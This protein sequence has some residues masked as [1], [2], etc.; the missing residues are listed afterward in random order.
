M[1]VPFF[2]IGLSMLWIELLI[3]LTG[4][5][6]C[7]TA[8]FFSFFVLFASETVRRVRVRRKSPEN[9]DL[10]VISLVSISVFF[11]CSLFMVKMH[12]SYNP[13]L[14]IAERFKSDTVTVNGQITE[15][16]PKSGSGNRRYVLTVDSI[17]SLTCD[18]FASESNIKLPV[19]GMK[20]LLT[21]KYFKGEL[22]DS[23]SFESKLYA[24]GDT[25]SMT[26]YYKSKGYY[27]GA[28]V[29]ENAE[30][31]AFLETSNSSSMFKR[32]V[33]V[34]RVAVQNIREYMDKQ[35]KKYSPDEYA[36]IMLGMLIGDKSGISEEYSDT[37]TKAGI[38]HLFSVSG[39]HI[40]LWSEI[41]YKRLLKC[42]LNK[43]LS[44]FVSIG[45]VVLFTAVT[46]FSR[47][48]LRAGIMMSV[49]FA[50]RMIFMDSDSLNSLGFSAFAISVA[51]PFCAGDVGFLLSFFS[52]LGIV[53]G[54]KP[55]MRPIRMYLR[56]INNYQV[57]RRVY[58]VISGFAV[59]ACAFVF[60][61]PFV[62]LFIGDVSLV[63]PLTNLLTG[64]AASALVLLSGIG[65]LASILPLVRMFC[66][67]VFLSAGLLTEYIVSVTTALAK[68]PYA[69]VSTDTAFITVALAAVMFL[70]AA[71]LLL[72]LS[73]ETKAESPVAD[74]LHARSAFDR[75]KPAP[76]AFGEIYSHYNFRARL[77]FWLSDIIIMSGI[78]A[79]LCF[80]F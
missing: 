59:S 35:L 10:R 13:S 34:A 11:A 37:F 31:S 2:T 40:S 51:D 33:A 39:F 24:L 4:T 76:I 15:I 45:F 71:A 69:Y 18:D 7:R 22:N 52:T 79:Y 38:V 77:V 27:V 72:P 9:T 49:F 57:R 44:S 68:L 19:G 80:N 66:Y 50:G 21:S 56:R 67:P 62:V 75:H 14:E 41:V 74:D 8:L 42:G 64:G 43:R 17:N 53:I 70:C 47:S 28:Y 58:G 30:R 3:S 46:G 61:F 60:T 65:V 20:I 5:A 54:V 29:Y 25:P 73:E 48:T 1:S 6:F 78:F 12:F 63:S 32:T 16:L 36:G 23:V 26:E 55:I